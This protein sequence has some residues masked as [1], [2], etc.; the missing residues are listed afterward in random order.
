M[1]LSDCL[2]VFDENVHATAQ[3]VEHRPNELI[4]CRLTEPLNHQSSSAPNDTLLLRKGAVITIRGDVVH[5][6]DRCL[7]DS[8]VG[9]VHIHHDN[10]TV[11]DPIRHQ[12]PYFIT[13]HYPPSHSHRTLIR[14]CDVQDLKDFAIQ[15]INE[16]IF[17]IDEAN[18]FGF[19]SQKLLAKQPP[20][21]LNRVIALKLFVQNQAKHDK[22]S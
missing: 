3:I 10:C 15:K 4:S 2:V 13:M 19:M 18:A 22:H 1:P 8:D 7:I 21:F 16:E 11:Y 6:T 9:S 20:R 5:D 17:E 12:K 14:K